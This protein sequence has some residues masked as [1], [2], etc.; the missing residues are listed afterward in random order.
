[1]IIFYYS[2]RNDLKWFQGDEDA[3]GHPQRPRQ[4]LIWQVQ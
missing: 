3:L 4:A 1:M 2:K